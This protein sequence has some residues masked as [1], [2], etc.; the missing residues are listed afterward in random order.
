VISHLGGSDSPHILLRRNMKILTAIIGV[1][2]VWAFLIGIAVLAFKADKWIGIA[3]IV[4][5]VILM[6]KLA[7]QEALSRRDNPPTKI[8]E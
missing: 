7:I 1:I 3:I 5:F 2:Y 8:E 4:A 6:G